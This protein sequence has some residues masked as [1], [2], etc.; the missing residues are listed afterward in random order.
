M[1]L[2]HLIAVV[3]FSPSAAIRLP[4]AGVENRCTLVTGSFFDAIPAGADAYLLKSV[5]HDWTTIGRWKLF[6]MAEN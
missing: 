6:A 5:P 1:N 3:A 2:A 4:A